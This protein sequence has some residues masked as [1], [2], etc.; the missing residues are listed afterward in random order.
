[1]NG[2][3]LTFICGIWTY[4]GKVTAEC[5]EHVTLDPAYQIFDAG[6]W[7]EPEWKTYERI[8]TP[9]CIRKSAVESWGVGKA[10]SLA[11]DTA[12]PLES[13]MPADL[14]SGLTIGSQ[15]AR[16]PDKIQMGEFDI[17]VTST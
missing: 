14:Q 12:Q 8:P 16:G 2:Q 9:W 4:A 3:W 13:A 11:K 10:P 1:M 6:D 17:T 15:S 7:K 5:N